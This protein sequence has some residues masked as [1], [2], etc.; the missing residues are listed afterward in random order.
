MTLNKALLLKQGVTAADE[1]ELELLYEKLSHVIAYPEEY[2]D[3]VAYIEELELSM[4]KLWKFP[5]DRN[6]HR[7]WKYIKGCRCPRQDNEDPMYFG[8]R[9]V[10]SDCS[11][12]WIGE[13]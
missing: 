6:Y 8:R 9:I 11:W 1:A 12:H 7:Y 13:K 2:E 10:V 4:Q 3:P 5:Q